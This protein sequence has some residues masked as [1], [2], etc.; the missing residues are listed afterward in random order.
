M[1]S[2]ER[3]QTSQHVAKAS[4][5][6]EQHLGHYSYYRNLRQYID[7]DDRIDAG[8]IEVDYQPEKTPALAKIPVI[9]SSLFGSAAG[10]AQTLEGL[11]SDHPDVAFFNTQV[12][13]VLSAERLRKFPYVLATDITPRQYDRMAEQYEHT[14]DRSRAVA[15][16]KHSV[17]LRVFRGAKRVVCWSSWCAESV[18]EEYGVAED[19]VAVVAPGVD[20]SRWQQR[21]ASVHNRVPRILFVGG[22][23][24]RK[25]GLMLVDAFKR[26][27]PGSAELHLVTRDRFVPDANG[28]V[29]HNDMM[30]NSPE[31]LSLFQT[32]DVFALPSQAEAFGIAAAEASASGLP[33]V[34]SNSGGLRDIVVDQVTGFAA[35]EQTP[36]NMAHRLAALIEDPELR[37]RMGGAARQRAE[38]FFDAAVNGR[39]VVDL[40]LEAA[41]LPT[42]DL[43]APAS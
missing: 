36:E 38:Q 27:D 35:A 25:G 30:P 9:G 14:V 7:T 12:P 32:S 10:R 1:K 40:V 37:R 28:I 22:D 24:E 19:R 43:S 23:L 3:V 21:E 15:A 41:G 6:M 39:R 42:I 5:V 34:A 20:L 29:V 2:T 8:W 26:L 13:A 17:N 11:S 4:F 33:I 31:L 18:I 16:A